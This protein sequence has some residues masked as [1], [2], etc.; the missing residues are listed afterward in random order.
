MCAPMNMQGNFEPMFVV[1]IG[2]NS[3]TRQKIEL[4]GKRKEYECEWAEEVRE[5]QQNIT[6]KYE[7]E[8]PAFTFHYT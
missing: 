3:A 8:C 2:N 6:G 4:E 7:I 5:E 1:N